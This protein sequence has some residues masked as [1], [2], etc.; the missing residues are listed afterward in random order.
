MG[1]L[2]DI[3]L[4]RASDADAVLA[5]HPQ[6]GW[7]TL[8]ANGLDTLKLADL[9]AVLLADDTDPQALSDEFELIA[10]KTAS[11]DD[12]LWLMGVP[13]RFQALLLA[14]PVAPVPGGHDSQRELDALRA[15]A[16]RWLAVDEPPDWP[17]AALTAWLLRLR[18]MV[19]QAQADQRSADP[20][21]VY[22]WTSL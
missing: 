8:G 7:P 14:L 19:Q 11:P 6:R 17:E 5:N 18:R 4:A 13:G 3:V 1:V 21:Q 16:A 2:T 15:I 9:Y 10:P 22:L 20:L 12:G